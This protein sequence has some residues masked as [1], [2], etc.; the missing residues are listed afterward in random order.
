MMTHSSRTSC[1]E[2]GRVRSE[3]I[4]QIYLIT[5]GFF[6]FA[7]VW[8]F[9]V[10]L[11][12]YFIFCFWLHCAAYGILGPEPGMESSPPAVEAWS[13]NHWTTREVSSVY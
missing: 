8:Y 12:F 13:L 9:F 2:S 3:L 6:C 1:Q 11:V 7:L 5:V 4:Q 10:S